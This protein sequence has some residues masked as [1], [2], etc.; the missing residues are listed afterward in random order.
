MKKNGKNIPVLE[1]IRIDT[2]MAL[3]YCY[4]ERQNYKVPT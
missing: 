1:Y 3:I 2:I 4:L